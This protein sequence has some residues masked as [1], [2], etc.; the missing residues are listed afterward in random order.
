MMMMMRCS[1]VLTNK[2]GHRMAR[3]SLLVTA[4]R[5][6]ATSSTPPPA[7]SFSFFTWYSRKLD[8][9][10]ITTK[11]I[12]AALISSTGNILAQR[13]THH[14]QDDTKPDTADSS[15]EDDVFH[16]DWDKVGRFAFLNVV[17]VAPVL[18]H[19]YQFIDK[20]VP[21]TSLFK[22]LQRTCW[23]QFV[24]TPCYL[25]VYLTA[26]STLDSSP[27]VE[28]TNMSYHELG[29]R[30]VSEEMGQL[31]VAEWIVWVPTMFLTFRFAPVKFQV[32]VINLVGVGLQTVL[33][34]SLKAMGFKREGK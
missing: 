26:L 8:T 25:P 3:L 10:P 31:I 34:L 29:Q 17:F 9:H 14:N 5:S 19:W 12:S 28:I 33:C 20:A 23:D 11:C 2:K 1:S 30:I 6:S 4:K 32:L 27:P 13:I 16:V 18:H 24:F 22:V 7:N 21:G 15:S